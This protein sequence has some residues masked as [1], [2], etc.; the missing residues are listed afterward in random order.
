M[1]GG[2]HSSCASGRS[3]PSPH[4]AGINWQ[5]LEHVALGG[6][7]CSSEF[8]RSSPQYQQNEGEPTHLAPGLILQYLSQAPE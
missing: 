8:I 4:T 7:H 1:P 6:S 5:V 2:S 3:M